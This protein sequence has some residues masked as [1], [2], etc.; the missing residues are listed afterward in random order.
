MIPCFY[1]PLD[2]SVHK[3]IVHIRFLNLLFDFFFGNKF[4]RREF[5]VELNISNGAWGHPLEFENLTLL[6]F[7]LKRDGSSLVTEGIHEVVV[8]SLFFPLQ[9]HFIVI[10]FC[11]T[12]IDAPFDHLHLLLVNF[13]GW[14]SFFL[15]LVNFR[16]LWLKLLFLIF[17]L[18]YD[19]NS[20]SQILRFNSS[21]LGI[22]WAR[23]F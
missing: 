2:L 19:L 1:D 22:R 14:L 20:L 23:L 9:N 6:L 21:L 8:L 5:H 11:S 10:L 4:F 3:L 17:D 13:D 15:F 16:I 7:V 12:S 18:F